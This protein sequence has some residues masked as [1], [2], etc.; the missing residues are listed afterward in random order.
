MNR[1]NA[2]NPKNNRQKWLKRTETFMIVMDIFMAHLTY[3]HICFP[4]YGRD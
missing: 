3:F 2:F 1:T 4:A